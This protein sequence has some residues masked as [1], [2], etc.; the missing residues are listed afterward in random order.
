MAEDRNI[1]HLHNAPPL[2]DQIALAFSVE[3]LAADHAALADEAQDLAGSAA[4]LTIVTNPAE[5]EAASAMVIRLRDMAG[6]IDR[7]HDDVKKPVWDA[8]KNVDL[9]FNGLNRSSGAVGPISGHKQRLERLIRDHGFKVAAENRRIAEEAAA[10]ERE[11]ARLAEQAAAKAEAENR[12]NVADVIMDAG[13][14]SEVIAE[15]LEAR[16][17]GPVQDLARVRTAVATSG[18]R[19]QP[20]FEIVDRDAL[21]ASLGPLGHAFTADAVMAAIRKFRSDTEAF[22]KWEFRDQDQHAQKRIV[23]A[24]PPLPGVEFFVEYVGSVR[25]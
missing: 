12:A 13:L 10:A 3:Q 15:S 1:D 23:V 7:E 17:Q 21:R 5:N 9:F 18:L 4:A 25:A 22:A 6:R 11:K 16:A 20:G 19:A 2:L 14:K 24:K 8:G